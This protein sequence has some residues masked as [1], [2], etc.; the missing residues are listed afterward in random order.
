MMEIVVQTMWTK[1]FMEYN[2]GLC[3]LCVLGVAPLDCCLVH[4]ES[5]SQGEGEVVVDS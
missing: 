3:Y 5:A 4:T 2:D 1:V